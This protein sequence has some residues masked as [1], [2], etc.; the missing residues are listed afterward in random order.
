M[1]LKVSELEKKIKGA[2]ES[3]KSSTDADTPIKAEGE[4]PISE[5][6]LILKE[7]NSI[8]V[9]CTNLT[10]QQKLAYCNSQR[11]FMKLY[12]KEINHR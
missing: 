12:L 8:L 5:N 9:K 1:S 2:K 11:Y 10:S 6:Y 3:I 7:L 4:F